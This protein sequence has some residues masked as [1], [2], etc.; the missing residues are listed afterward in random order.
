[1]ND[2]RPRQPPRA[3]V[4]YYVTND[5]GRMPTCHLISDKRD[6]EEEA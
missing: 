2:P 3:F 5:C 1:M 6:R 4:T